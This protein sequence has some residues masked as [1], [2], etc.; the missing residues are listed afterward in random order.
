[1]TNKEK[2]VFTI[3]TSEKCYRFKPEA[4][5]THAPPNK[6]I[7]E[8]VTFD[9]NQAP[10]VLYIGGA[11]DKTIRECLEAH[12]QGTLEPTASKLFESH[13]DLYFDFIVD[14][15]AKTLEDALAIHAWLIRKYQPPYN[16]DTPSPGGLQEGDIEV[17]EPD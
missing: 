3:H 16:K 4:L 9:E 1:M 17:I 2:K 12:A 5:E 6:G 7:Y 14:W 10:K 15:D 13:P 8:L 11:F